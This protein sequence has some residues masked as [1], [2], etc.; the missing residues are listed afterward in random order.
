MLV[1]CGI[2]LLLGLIQL[3][4]QTSPVLLRTARVFLLNLFQLSLC[5]LQPFRGGLPGCLSK[6]AEPTVELFPSVG[7][8]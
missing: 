4:L 8:L 7:E 3:R 6:S 1:G 5:C 2:N